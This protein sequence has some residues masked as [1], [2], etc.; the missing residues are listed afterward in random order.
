MVGS[1]RQ[2]LASW[3]GVVTATRKAELEQNVNNLVK[4]ESAGRKEHKEMSKSQISDE[5]LGFGERSFSAAGAAFLSAIIVNP[6]DV[7]KVFLLL[8]FFFNIQY[9]EIEIHIS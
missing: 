6:L 7:V 1:T 9:I 2:G 8:F 5:N 3:I 4:E